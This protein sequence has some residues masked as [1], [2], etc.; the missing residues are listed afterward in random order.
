MF[1]RAELEPP[2]LWRVRTNTLSKRDIEELLDAY[3]HD[4]VA[5]LCTALSR[6]VEK[7]DGTW[8]SLASSVPASVAPAGQLQRRDIAALDAVVK[9]LVENRRLQQ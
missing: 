8:E 1:Q 7:H 9:H 6:I 3:D 2:S 5:A 4:P